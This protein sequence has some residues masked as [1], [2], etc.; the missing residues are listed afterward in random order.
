MTEVPVGLV[1]FNGRA[2][3]GICIATASGGIPAFGVKAGDR[4]Q[5]TSLAL[6]AFGNSENVFGSFAPADNVVIQLINADLSTTNFVALVFRRV[7]EE[8]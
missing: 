1:T 6:G 2:T 3:P 7:E 8:V 5:A 4:I